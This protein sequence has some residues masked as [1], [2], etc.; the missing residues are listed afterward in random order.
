MC[1]LL[2]NGSFSSD[3]NR[4]PRCFMQD[5]DCAGLINDFAAK[6][7][8]ALGVKGPFSAHEIE[9]RKTLGAAEVWHIDSPPILLTCVAVLRGKPTE[10]VTQNVACSYFENEYPDGRFPWHVKI[11]EGAVLAESDISHF[12]KDH[13]VFF[14][15]HD[16]PGVEKIIHRAPGDD[17]GRAIFLARWK[18]VHNPSLER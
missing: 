16:L 8:G 4:P 10:Y 9:I 12:P 7:L 3:P 1:G 6:A 18:P 2:E 5:L 15:A 11:K 17:D 14:A 13:F